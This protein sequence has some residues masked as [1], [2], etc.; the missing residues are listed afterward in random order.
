MDIAHRSTKYRI[1]RHLD[2][3]ATKVQPQDITFLDNWITR[4][5]DLKTSEH[6]T[7][8]R[9]SLIYIKG[10]AYANLFHH[11]IHIIFLK[12]SIHTYI[13]LTSYCNVL[14]TFPKSGSTATWNTNM[15]CCRS[16]LSNFLFKDSFGIL[17][18]RTNK[19]LSSFLFIIV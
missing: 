9:I 3:K 12:K 11:F 16:L 17:N 6:W 13:V 19:L 2:N 8:L 18:I 4:F 10:R 1:S 15:F 7:N 14:I 5:L